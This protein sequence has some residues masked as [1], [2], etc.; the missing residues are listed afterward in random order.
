MQLDQQRIIINDYLCYLFVYLYLFYV[1]FYF[2]LLDFICLVISMI[3]Y[4]LCI[5][6]DLI[7]A[8]DHSLILKSVH[9]KFTQF[10]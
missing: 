9:S 7:I 8:H 1:Y 10:M 2:A 4:L 3:V 6:R 5:V